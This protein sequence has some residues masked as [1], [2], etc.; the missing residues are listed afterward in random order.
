MRPR[1]AHYWELPNA[2][3]LDKVTIVNR[4]ETEILAHTPNYP[5]PFKTYPLVS[6]FLASS[7]SRFFRRKRAFRFTRTRNCCP[8]VE[9][10]CQSGLHPVKYHPLVS[11][12]R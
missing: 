2:D 7:C 4:N 3:H 8:M 10:L 5:L 6:I 9:S 1:R 12:R 11:Y